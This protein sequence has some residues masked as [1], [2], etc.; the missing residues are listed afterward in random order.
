MSYRLSS[1]GKDNVVIVDGS[2]SA[3]SNHNDTSPN[4]T[5]NNNSNDNVSDSNESNNDQIDD[6]VNDVIDDNN[7]TNF[8]SSTAS[9]GSSDVNAFNWEGLLQ[10]IALPRSQPKKFRGDPLRYHAFITSFHSTVSQVPDDGFKLQHLLS[11]RQ[12]TVYSSIQYCVL[13]PATEGYQ[14]AL[15]KLKDKFGDADIITKAWSDKILKR[16]SYHR[17][18]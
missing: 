2:N 16:C 1:S 8:S 3:S 15:K 11:L 13:K 12:G 6:D 18:P 7:V 4:N 10:A 9:S 14:A 5:Q 17:L